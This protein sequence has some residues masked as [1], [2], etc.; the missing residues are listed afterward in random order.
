MSWI[1]S[2]GGFNVGGDS[3]VPLKSRAMPVNKFSTN[4]TLHTMFGAMK[5]PGTPIFILLLQN[6]CMYNRNRSPRRRTNQST[7]SSW[8]RRSSSSTSIR[9]MRFL[10]NSKA[11]KKMALTTQE[12]DMDTPRPERK[13][14][15]KLPR[16]EFCAQ[17]YLYTSAG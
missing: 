2:M 4:A 12:R 3:I 8:Q 5:L 13:G 9:L 15:V 14:S 16:M 10:E 17:A 11:V 1:C 6:L 7:P